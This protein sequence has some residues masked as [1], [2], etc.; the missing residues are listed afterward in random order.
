[1]LSQHH[2][3]VSFPGMGI[4]KDGSIVKIGVH[5]EN[6]VI[7]NR[8]LSL[9]SLFTLV[10]LLQPPLLTEFDQSKPLSEII[11]HYLG[12]WNIDASSQDYSLQFSGHN[13]NYV[14]EKNRL[15]IRHGTVLVLTD[16]VAKTCKTILT[17]LKVAGPD[18]KRSLLSTLVKLCLD[19]A[20]A[21]EFIF[22]EGKDFLVQAIESGLIKPEEGLGFA[23]EAFVELINHGICRYLLLQKRPINSNFLFLEV[24]TL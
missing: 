10:F 11:E 17:R 16:S 7:T 21:E 1:M 9:E 4:V 24:G 19:P 8:N 15:E 23:L 14:T 5:M 13:E 22:N 20:F 18:E 12:N 6:R 3:L 2:N